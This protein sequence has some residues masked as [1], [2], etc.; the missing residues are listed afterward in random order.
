MNKK[1]IRF[2]YKGSAVAAAGANFKRGCNQSFT[3]ATCSLPRIGG[4]VK[5]KA[6]FYFKPGILF[7]RNGASKASGMLIRNSD[8]LIGKFETKVYSG[9]KNVC[10]RNGLFR[11]DKLEVELRSIKEA[12]RT[13][14]EISIEIILDREQR[15]RILGY[16]AEWE[17]SK[18]LH[19]IRTHAQAMAKMKAPQERDSKNS[20]CFY[21]PVTNV[22]WVNNENIPPVGCVKIDR[23]V[24][25]VKG[26][27]KIYLAEVMRGENRVRFSLA[28]IELDD[29]TRVWEPAPTHT[30]SS[31]PVIPMSDPSP[32]PD[33]PP[34]ILFCE[35]ESNGVQP[36]PG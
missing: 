2:S 17:I 15:F 1:Q 20:Y 36:P 18:E 22:T 24:I 19:D 3:R 26:L 29:T 30:P 12:W 21:S 7:F 33:P 4:A 25:T 27:G 28:R 16:E 6:C 8:D 10:V 13:E 31:A 32:P 9:L 14:G 35:V 11:A 23:N 34:E 5:R